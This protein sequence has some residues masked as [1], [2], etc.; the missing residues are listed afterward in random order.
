[1]Q[2]DEDRSFN[3]NEKKSRKA[4]SKLNLRPVPELTRVVMKHGKDYLLVFDNCEVFKYPDSDSY[5][6][7]GT[8]QVQDLNAQRRAQTAEQYKKPAEEVSAPSEPTPAST[9]ENV[10]IGDLDET[11]VQ[12]V[13]EQTGKSK[14]ECVA[15]LKAHNGD[16]VDS[17]MSL[18]S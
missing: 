3:R 14:S 12:T 5:V 9:E 2:S 18:S 10:D 15:A 13:M 11:D 1:M 7:F 6:I 17:I 4:L 16:L 8:P